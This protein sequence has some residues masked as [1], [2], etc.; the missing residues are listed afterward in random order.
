MEIA[1]GMTVNYDVSSTAALQAVG[2]DPQA[3]LNFLTN[4]NT[5]MYV[6]D[7]VVFYGGTLQIGSDNPVA[8]NVTTTILFNNVPINTA[9][10]PAQMVMA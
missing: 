2:I 6:T 1:S 4:V 10:D 5:E 3:T 9:I 7:M 8:P